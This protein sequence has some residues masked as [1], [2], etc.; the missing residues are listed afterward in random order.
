MVG[1][2]LLTD[3]RAERFESASGK[4]TA[5]ICRR[6]MPNGAPARKERA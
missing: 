3:M 2:Q 6:V 1:A 5:L 4:V